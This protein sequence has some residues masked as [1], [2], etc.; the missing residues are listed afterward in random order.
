MR[1]RRW[2][3][4]ISPPP[5]APIARRWSP[6]KMLA[7]W[8]IW[9]R[10]CWR[11]RACRT[12]GSRTGRDR[13]RQRRSRPRRGAAGAAISERRSAGDQRHRSRQAHRAGG[14]PDPLA[15]GRHGGGKADQPRP[16]C[17]RPA[18]PRSSP[19]PIFRK[20]WV[21]AH[22]FD[23]DIGSVHLGDI[24]QVT[25][26]P[27]A[28]AAAARWTISAPKWTPTPARWRCG[29]WWTIPAISSSARCMCR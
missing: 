13:R 5:S 15:A 8:P 3:R 4:P 23:S 20:V 27:A 22:I 17:C 1:W 12:R 25:P 21:M 10:I 9:T 11:I 26:A 18:P 29:W 28:H 7:S 24:A 14:R 19:S 16:D 2:S 6:P